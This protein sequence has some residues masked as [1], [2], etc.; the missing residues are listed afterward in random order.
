MFN[1]KNWLKKKHPEK[2][3]CSRHDSILMYI[4]ACTHHKQITHQPHQTEGNTHVILGHVENQTFNLL[5][6]F[7]FDLNQH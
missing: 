2:I 7:Q 6:I 4:H 3:V 1:N 5:E